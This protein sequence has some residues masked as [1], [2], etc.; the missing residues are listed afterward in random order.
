MA[1]FLIVYVPNNER[2]H[3]NP[4]TKF[5][6]PNFPCHIQHNKFE[7]SKTNRKDV[8]DTKIPTRVH[9]LQSS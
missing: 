8:G 3:Q 2:T 9:R 7:L 4:Q 5:N 6:T 1:C